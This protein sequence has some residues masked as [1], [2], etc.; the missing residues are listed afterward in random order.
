M[1]HV[2]E[3]N[4]SPQWTWEQEGQLH[5]EI[6]VTLPAIEIEKTVMQDIVSFRNLD[7][8]DVRILQFGIRKKEEAAARW[9]ELVLGVRGKALHEGDPYVE[10]SIQAVQSHQHIHV[11][12]IAKIAPVSRLQEVWVRTSTLVGDSYE[13]AVHV[14]SDLPIL[15]HGLH[16]DGF[17]R[18]ITAYRSELKAQATTNG[19]RRGYETIDFE[20][21][22]RVHYMHGVYEQAR[23][24]PGGTPATPQ[25]WQVSVRKEG[26]EYLCTAGSRHGALQLLLNTRLTTTAKLGQFFEEVLQKS[27]AHPGPYLIAIGPSE[28]EVMQQMDLRAAFDLALEDLHAM[29]ASYVEEQH[30]RCPEPQE[31]FV[32]VGRVQFT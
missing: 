32:H 26:Q 29:V 7:F 30:V 8:N 18:C 20:F 21:E 13:Q 24:Y 4:I 6:T 28:R 10:K 22:G 17:P 15:F 14:F 31:F 1:N 2:K 12:I 3:I 25:L 23:D 5:I 27:Q 11:E 19:K 9:P 16:W